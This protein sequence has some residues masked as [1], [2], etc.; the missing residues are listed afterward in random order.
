MAARVIAMM[1][2]VVKMEARIIFMEGLKK[3][4]A[5][6]GKIE[7]WAVG[8][9]L[10]RKKRK[11]NSSLR[12]PARSQERTGGKR[13]HF[14]RN[15][16]SSWRRKTSREI[17]PGQAGAQQCC[18]RIQDQVGNRVRRF[19]CSVAGPVCSYDYGVGF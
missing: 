8:C 1:S 9:A 13:A 12:S 7:W 5:G 14:G 10:K 3:D 19:G 17:A 4:S 11:P 2:A 16:V 15:D 18:A 6:G